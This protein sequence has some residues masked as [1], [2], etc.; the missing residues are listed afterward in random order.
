[1][2]LCFFSSEASCIYRLS[3]SPCPSLQHITLTCTT[4]FLRIKLR[5][6]SKRYSPST[7]HPLPLGSQ[8][9]F[10]QVDLHQLNVGPIFQ[11]ML[12][13]Y[14]MAVICVLSFISVHRGQVE[15][16]VVLELALHLYIPKTGDL[17]E[18]SS[19]T[20]NPQIH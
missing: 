20:L 14:V 12:Y 2:G 18:C 7:I 9:A 19:K 13:K 10:F 5:P 3:C 17:R 4:I 8:E 16:A 15:K 1:M 6:G 11:C